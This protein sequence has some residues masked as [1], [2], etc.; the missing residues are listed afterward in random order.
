MSI[1]EPIY[2]DFLI[3]GGGPAG[4][5][6]AIRAREMNPDLDVTI[7]EKA[8]ITRSG[9]A[10]RGMD[11]LNN[12]VVP[13]VGTVDEYVEAVGIV[14]DGVYN[15]DISRVIGERSFGI[16]QRLEAWG[17]T[18]PRGDDGGYIVTG[19]HPKGK[20]M[21]EMRGELK[22]HTAEQTRKAGVRIMNRHPVV[23]LI[24]ENNRMAGVIALDLTDG[25]F[26]VFI[27]PAVLL[28]AGGA[29]RIGLPN[30]GYLHGT[31]DCPWCNGEAHKLGYEAGAGLT[32]FEYTARSAMTR[33]YNGPGQST[34]IRHNAWLVNGLGERFME[35]HDPERM[36][37]APAGIRMKA[38][39][40]EEQAGRGPVAFSFSHLSPSVIDIIE[41]GIFETERPTMKEYFRNKGIDLRKTT[42]EV[43]MTEIY[44]CGGHGLSGLVGDAWGETDVPGL[45][46]A[47]DCLANPYGFLPRGHGRG[48]G[49]G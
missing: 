4:C 44:L 48:R 2:T 10:G 31:F 28:A 49:R 27:A 23:E 17:C 42:V 39:L 43:V 9:A 18:F 26:K 24:K 11:A 16:L 30:T 7:L 6:A 40:E 35:R 19:F 25:R 46:A 22:Q 33:D 34:F 45:F 32:G 36:E 29:A 1:Y 41:E 47:G 37:H 5:M 21:V 3:V 13:G 14:A 15:P 20:F 12:V 38:M 8:E